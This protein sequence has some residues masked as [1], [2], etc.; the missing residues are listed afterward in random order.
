MHPGLGAQQWGRK[1]AAAQA[2]ASLATMLG[3]GM[4]AD[5]PILTSALLQAC[6][7]SLIAH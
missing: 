6:P 4:L 5:V 1:R 7:R 2:T 3:D